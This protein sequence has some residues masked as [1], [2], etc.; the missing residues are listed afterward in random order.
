MLHVICGFFFL[1]HTTV[2]RA[3]QERGLDPASQEALLKT[4]QLMRDAKL[5]QSAVG[6]DPKAKDMDSK[7][8]DFAGSDENTQEIYSLGA[9][10]MENLVKESGGDPE[11]MQKLLDEAKKNPS[12]FA[13]RFSPAQKA[14]LNA[15]A[16]KIPARGK[17]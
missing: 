14:K 2:A 13:A 3:Q 12:A 17:P 15:V 6:S 11:K 8:R 9:D 10:V 16:E 5:R 7:V 1:L 4:Q